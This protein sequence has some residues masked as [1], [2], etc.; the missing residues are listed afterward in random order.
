MGNSRI[1]GEP[2]EESVWEGRFWNHVAAHL[3]NAPRAS[4][5]KCSGKAFYESLSDVSR[6]CFWC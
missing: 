2:A 1:T 6:Q 4:A 5:E 3:V